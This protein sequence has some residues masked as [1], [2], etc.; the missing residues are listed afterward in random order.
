MAMPAPVGSLSNRVVI[1]AVL[2]LALAG[3]WA[4]D[5]QAP[6][7][8]PVTPKPGTPIPVEPTP[9]PPAPAAALPGHW[10][11]IPGSDPAAP[12]VIGLHGRGDSAAGFAGVAS[13]WGSNLNWRMVQALTPWKSNGGANHG[14]TWFSLRDPDVPAAE[15]SRQLQLAVDQVDAHVR[16]LQRHGKPLALFGFS[17]GCFLAARYAAVFPDR[18]QGVLCFGGGLAPDPVPPRPAGGAGPAFHF[19]HG[20]ADTVIPPESSADAV[21]RLHAAGFSAQRSLF[22]A[23]HTLPRAL[24]Q[25]LTAW[26]GGILGVAVAIPSDRGMM[27]PA[28]VPTGA[29]AP[30]PAPRSTP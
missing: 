15:K 25:P 21:S 4:Q 5:L 1:P 6:V 3:W 30:A 22:A 19:V 9:V 10:L 27:L 17:Q 26:L 24:R 16:D 14:F 11:D 13:Q 29:A 2:A 12:W 8:G 28:P 7:S 18:V 23:G 20:T